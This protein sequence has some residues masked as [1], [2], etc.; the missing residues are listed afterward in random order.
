[1]AATGMTTMEVRKINRHNI[2]TFIY[3]QKTTSKQAIVEALH[4]SLSTVTQNLKMLEE[5]GLICRSGYYE[6]TGGRKAQTIEIVRDAQITLGIDI[7]KDRV[8]LTAVDL[9]GEVTAKISRELPFS[10]DDGYYRSL[11]TLAEDLIRENDLDPKRLLGAG[12]AI[13]GIITADGT[14]V[15]YGQILNHTGL[16]LSDL[17]RHIPCKSLLFHDS[18]AAARAELW[19]RKNLVNAIVLLLNQNMGGALILN[20]QIF[21]GLSMHGGL[22]EHMCIDPDGPNCYCGKKGCL[23][24]YCSA[25][26]LKKAAGSSLDQFFRNVRRGDVKSCQIW[27]EY[28]E[29]LA[30]ALRNLLI[31]LDSEVIVSGLLASYM[32]QDDFDRLETLVAELSPFPIPEHILLPGQHGPLAPAIGSA[33]FF[34]ERWLSQV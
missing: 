1:M 34:V 31:L 19:G 12:I 22:I 10:A 6:S 33:L 21:D 4:L 18:K 20:R 32:T 27:N 24:T 28:L 8:H 11:G 26:S 13:Q 3:E 5:E 15:S 16:K 14:A 23:E 29:K 2:Y 25:D 30:Y 7:L 17:S 9:Y